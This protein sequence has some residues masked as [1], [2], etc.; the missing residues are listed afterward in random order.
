M[1]R[2]YTIDSGQLLANQ[3]LI[4]TPSQLLTIPPGYSPLGRSYGVGPLQILNPARSSKSH[5]SVNDKYTFDGECKL[6]PTI[7]LPISVIA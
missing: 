1:N 5:T 7:K 2:R 4:A 3:L 6:Y